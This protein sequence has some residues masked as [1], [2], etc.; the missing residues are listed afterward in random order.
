MHLKISPRIDTIVA[1]TSRRSGLMALPIG[2][3][4]A[5]SVTTLNH[6]GVG[7]KPTP[8]GPTGLQFK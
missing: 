2:S 6:R 8:I 7:V 4:Y 5:M 3:V 1:L